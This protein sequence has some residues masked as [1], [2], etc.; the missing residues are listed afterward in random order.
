MV[1]KMN[2]FKDIKNESL[3][4][5]ILRFRVNTNSSYNPFE[6]KKFS[7]ELRDFKVEWQ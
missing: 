1:L 7:I 5:K 4:V 3:Y 6:E 2:F